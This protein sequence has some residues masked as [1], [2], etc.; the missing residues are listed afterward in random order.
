M[1]T[2]TPGASYMG[3]EEDFWNAKNEANEF[4][5]FLTS[6]NMVILKN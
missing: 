5:A 6:V 3:S 4:K 1:D 2:H